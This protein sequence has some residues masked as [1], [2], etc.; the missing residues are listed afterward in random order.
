MKHRTLK[1]LNNAL[2]LVITLTT[3]ISCSES[4]ATSEPTQTPPET[5]P[6][7]P[8]EDTAEPSQ[9]GEV[10]SLGGFGFSV[11]GYNVLE[12]VPLTYSGD[13]ILL[14]FFL[15]GAGSDNEVG[16]MFF[17]DGVAQPYQIIETTHPDTTS[18]THQDTLL[19]K[20][21]LSPD[22]RIEFTVSITP[23]IGSAGDELGL[24]PVTLLE[25]SFFPESEAGN[26]GIY[27]QGSFYLPITIQM[28]ADGSRQIVDHV[29]DLDLAPIP[30]LLF[31][32]AALDASGRI[33]QPNFSLYADAFLGWGEL[34]TTTTKN[35][36][37]DLHLSGYGGV[38]VLYRVTIF[39]NHQPVMIEGNESFLIQTYY[40]QVST[41]TFTLDISGYDR[42]NSLYAI[43]V[44]VGESYK[45]NDIYCMK[46]RTYL[47]INDLAEPL[48]LNGE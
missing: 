39:I 10:T 24:F 27:H 21:Q 7:E 20:F 25:P 14:S 32:D 38:E 23:I 5:N 35:G 29:V 47:L 3:L 31:E 44:P 6:F 30:E 4:P 19:G 13:P 22:T 15:D 16:L 45:N 43:V 2:L 33:N 36:K 8:T 34:A 42:M 28:G 26:F 11:I 37:I 48:T 17:L 1:F 41:Y 12:G 18:P 40:D 46:T 9:S